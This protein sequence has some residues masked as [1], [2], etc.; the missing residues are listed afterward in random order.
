MYVNVRNKGKE[1]V[2]EKCDP[3]DY[4]IRHPFFF[5][6]RAGGDKTTRIASSNTFL[7]PFC[8]S[9]EHSKYFAE[10]ISFANCTA[11]V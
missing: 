9:A 6:G 1:M 4:K 5:F 3:A 2:R 10:P 7:R 8:V 11:C